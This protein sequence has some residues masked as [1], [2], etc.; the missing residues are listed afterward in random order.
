MISAFQLDQSQV[1]RLA[2][3]EYGDYGSRMA[4]VVKAPGYWGSLEGVFSARTDLKE[5]STAMW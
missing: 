4:R 2:S 3:M 1:A 5:L